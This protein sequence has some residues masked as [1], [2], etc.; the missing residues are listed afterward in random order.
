MESGSSQ[1]GR[2]RRLPDRTP[3]RRFSGSVESP[4]RILGVLA[5]SGRTAAPAPSASL[6]RA[7]LTSL[8]PFLH[9]CRPSHRHSQGLAIIVPGDPTPSAEDKRATQRLAE[10]GQILGIELLDHISLEDNRW[11]SLK[12][13]GVF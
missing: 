7:S 9:A 11:I 3:Y 4:T 1:C 8:R 2:R 13:R 5:E 12:E 6:P 10:A